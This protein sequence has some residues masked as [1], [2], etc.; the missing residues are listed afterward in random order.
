MFWLSFFPYTEQGENPFRIHTSKN[1][2]MPFKR[3]DTGSVTVALLGRGNWMWN[4][5]NCWLQKVAQDARLTYNMYI[6]KDL[7]TYISE[8]Q[9]WKSCICQQFG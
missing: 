9:L 1:T 4:L 5:L 6:P 3:P 7:F 2:D 8:N